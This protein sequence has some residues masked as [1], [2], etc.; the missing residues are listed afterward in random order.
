MTDATDDHAAGTGDLDPYADADGRLN[1]L[2][3]SEV[4]AEIDALLADPGL[5]ESPSADLGDRIV[6][7]ITDAVHDEAE[8][9]LESPEAASVDTAG[10]DAEVI[11]LGRRRTW[12]TMLFGA[13]AAFAIVLGGVVVFSALSDSPPQEAFSADLVPTGLVPDVSGE[14]SVTEMQSGLEIEL[15]APT[16]P[17]RAGGLFYEGWLLLADDR[18]VPIGTFHEGA[19]V[20]LWAGIEL[21]EVVRMTITLEEAVPG[22]S[23]DQASSGEVVLKVD[24]PPER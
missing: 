11:P 3:A 6:A 1:D 8:V 10:H 5:W 21:D 4:G 23:P 15:D 22:M 18:L 13:A 9:A 20:T 17:R 2:F 24:F 14:V 7:S 16:L 19:N 12:S